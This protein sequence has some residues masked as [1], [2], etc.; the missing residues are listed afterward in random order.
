MVIERGRR[1]G[2]RKGDVEKEIET[3][4][5]IEREEGEGEREKLEAMRDRKKGR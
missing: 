3:G 1:E 4:R 5:D 2:Q